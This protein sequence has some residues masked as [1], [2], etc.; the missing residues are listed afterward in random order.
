VKQ[1]GLFN[2]N[3]VK[4]FEINWDPYD[5]SDGDDVHNSIR[6]DENIAKS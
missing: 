3:H 5:D 4:V 1:V 6:S 2:V